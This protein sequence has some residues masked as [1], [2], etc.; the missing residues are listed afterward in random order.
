M[1]TDPKE[2]ERRK[3]IS[4]SRQRHGHGGTRLVGDRPRP[5]ST[6]RAWQS[7]K[8]RCYNP[9]HDFYPAYG[10]RGIVVCDRWLESFDNFLAD[11]GEKPT[12]RHSIDRI[13][14]DGNYE[15]TNCRWATPL[16]QASHTRRNRNLTFNGETLHCAEWARRTGL[17]RSLIEHRL[18]SGWSTEKTLSTPRLSPKEVSGTLLAYKGET[19]PIVDWAARYGLSINCL[20]S[21]LKSGWPPEKA[22]LTPSRFSR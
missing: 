7:A 6:Y 22:L 8:D 21:R 19:L 4:S 15:P 3:K 14:N 2:L 20:R 5:S 13:N 10:G 16:E 12:P 1:N 18:E 11:M 9:N 17:S